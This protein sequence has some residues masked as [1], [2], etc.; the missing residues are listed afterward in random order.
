MTITYHDDFALTPKRCNRCN[1]LFIFEP[2]DI[3]YKEVGIEHHSLKQIKCI[4]CLRAA[5][6]Q[7][8][9]K[10]RELTPIT[11]PDNCFI[12]NLPGE[13]STEPHEHKHR[14]VRRNELG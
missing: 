10:N 7:D 8:F 2:F 13:I 11:T 6:H 12:E 14:K 9:F 3:F 4:N 1:R 5:K